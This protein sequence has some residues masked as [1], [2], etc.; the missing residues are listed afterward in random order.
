MTN[1]QIKGLSVYINVGSG[2]KAPAVSIAEVLE[3]KHIKVETVDFFKSLHLDGP[4]RFWKKSWVM[5]VSGAPFLMKFFSNKVFELVSK[6]FFVIKYN[7]FHG[8]K[9]LK[10]ILDNNPDFIISTHFVSTNFILNIVRK[11]NLPVSVFA[12]NAEV[13]GSHISDI[14]PDID[15]FFV[16]SKEGYNNMTE[17]GQPEKTI[18]LSGFPLD[19]KYKRQFPRVQ[20]LRIQLGLDPDR[21]TILFS[22][23]GE[24]IGDI[25]IIKRVLE[26]YRNIQIMAVCGRSETVKKKL[27][28]VKQKNAFENLFIYG[29]VSNMPELLYC[30]DI[31]AGKSGMNLAFESIYMK[32]PFL[33]TM[34]MENELVTAHYIHDNGFGWYPGNSDEQEEVIGRCITD[35]Q[36]Y[37]KFVKTLEQNTVSFDAGSIADSIAD[38]TIKNK[39]S[40][41]RKANTL[42][43]DL[44][45]TLCDIPIS[46]QWEAI[47]NAG[48]KNVLQY[49]DFAKDAIDPAAQR[50]VDKK[51]VLR[52]RAKKDLNE[53]PIRM[54]LSDFFSE[55]AFNSSKLSMKEWE[56]LEYLFI[57]P[58]MEITTGFKGIKDLLADL[59][60]R[61]DLYLLSNNVSRILVTSI[62]KKLGIASFFKDVFVSADCGFR[63]P[64]MEFLQYV[65]Q[66]TGVR[67]ENAVMIGDRLSQDIRMAVDYNMKSVF[68]NI[69]EHEDNAGAGDVDYFYMVEDIMELKTVFLT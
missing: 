6:W 23:G 48:I 44:A 43:F 58:E 64:H 32:K 31:S 53:Y 20:S 69:L 11:H 51:A 42:Y 67:P 28:T 24:G 37:D 9:V 66:K 55:T 36:Y 14:Y 30:C 16:A 33:V 65:T 59:S 21:F 26:K 18:I 68:V 3:D 35:H 13:L 4:D 56:K 12:Y 62:A 19:R 41:L 63:K 5:I 2:F 25:S 27:E 45:G 50:F 38:I 47:N 22:F 15:A 10:W 1:K 17:L 57:K 52:K 60:S 61:Y 7:L 40:H 54:Q 29:F 39:I 8:Q 34:A 49:L 46:G